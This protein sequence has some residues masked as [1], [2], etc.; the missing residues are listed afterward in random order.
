MI[1][2]RNVRSLSGL[3][4]LDEARLHADLPGGAVSIESFEVSRWRGGCGDLPMHFQ[5]RWLADWE[6]CG[7]KARPISTDGVVEASC[8]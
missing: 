7:R 2:P 8:L 5:W 3:P 6:H 1:C 4:P